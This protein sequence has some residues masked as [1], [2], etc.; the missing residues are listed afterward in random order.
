MKKVLLILFFGVI[1][2]TL[3]AQTILYPVIKSYGGVR[4]D[5]SFATNYTDATMDYNIVAEI[6]W[7]PENK[8]EAHVGLDAIARMYNLHVYAGIPR[9]QLH[10]AV[11]LYAGSAGAALNNEAY[12]ARYEVDNPNLK[13]I[14]E[15]K[16]AGVEVIVCG[17]S[18]MKAKI[19]PV[20]INPN[21][22]IAV[23][24]ITAVS[25]FQLQGYAF[26]KM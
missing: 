20:T 8:S 13:L 26:F 14:E 23:S 18:V 4:D 5:Q 2:F 3:Q 9:E 17:Q 10:I 6:G 15:L 25:S 11:V 21:V 12:R 19:D 24:R 7:R 16:E 22:T 1:S